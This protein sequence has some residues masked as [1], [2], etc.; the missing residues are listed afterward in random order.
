M[1][2]HLPS[3]LSPSPFISFNGRR[4]GEGGVLFL[5]SNYRFLSYL[6][7]FLLR[8]AFCIEHKAADDFLQRL[9]LLYTWHLFSTNGFFPTGI[10]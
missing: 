5:L 4:G 6:G 1:F 3:F 8:D 2:M 9:F 7:C 10:I